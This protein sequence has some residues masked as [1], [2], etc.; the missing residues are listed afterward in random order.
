MREE[1]LN[2]SSSLVD[3]TTRYITLLGIISLQ[4]SRI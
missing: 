4:Q 3:S 2:P 1:L